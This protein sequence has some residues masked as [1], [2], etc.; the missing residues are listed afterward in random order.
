ME[1]HILEHLAYMLRS[2][3]TA[4]ALLYSEDENGIFLRNICTIYQTT[5]SRI[6]EDRVLTFKC[7]LKINVFTKNVS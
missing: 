3:V 1:L 2:E 4:S 6:H 7:Y 5:R